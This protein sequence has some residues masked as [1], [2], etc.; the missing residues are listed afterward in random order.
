M[1]GLPPYAFEKCRKR[2]DENVDGFGPKDALTH[3]ALQFWQP[4]R[5]GGVEK[6]LTFGPNGAAAIG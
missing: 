5:D 4:T 1:T 3:L 2:L 6:T